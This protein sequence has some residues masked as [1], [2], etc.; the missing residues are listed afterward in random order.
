[1]KENQISG[2]SGTGDLGGLTIHDDAAFIGF[3][4]TPLMICTKVDLPAPFAPTSPWT[5][6]RS[7]SRLTPRSARTAPKDFA[8]CLA[9]I[10]GCRWFISRV[11]VPPGID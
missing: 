3:A 4:T 6:P 10:K 1:M 8:S 11:V 9:A 7:I 5:L 2:N